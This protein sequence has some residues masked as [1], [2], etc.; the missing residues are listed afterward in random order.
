[1][2]NYKKLKE[3]KGIYKHL[4][5]G[6]FMA[7]KKVKGRDCQE[8]FCT[9]FEAK[10]WLK[11]QAP[12]KL[13]PL[14]VFSTL[15]EVWGAM[16]R[17]HFPN[18]A[19]ST[20]EMWIRRYE[21]WKTIE[22]L[23]M[24]AITPSKISSWIN[25][26]TQCYK[27]DFYAS[28]GRGKAGRCNLNNE[29]NLFVT[30]FNW[31]KESEEFEAEAIKL[32]CPIKKKH[33]KEG[34]I[35]P[36]PQKLKQISFEEAQR[37]WERLKPLYRNLAELQFYTASRIGEVA[38]LQWKNIDLANR[39]LLIKETSYWDNRKKVFV[40]LNPFPKTKEIRVCFITDE[41]M[42]ILLK[43]KALQIPGN[44]FV[45]H[46]EGKPLNYCSIQSNYRGGQRKSGVPYSGS[47]IMR[48]GMAYLARKVGG[49]EAVMAMTG[50][51]DIKLANHYSKGNEHDQ[52]ETSLKIMEYLRNS[53]KAE[54]VAQQPMD[55]VVSIL[56]KSTVN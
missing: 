33:R 8:T 31:Y 20:Q 43:Q 16:L 3:A 48:H 35:K 37:F 50:H 38:G 41:I 22:H 56:Q 12:E 45:F 53:A 1:M 13:K 27:S 30:I 19:P 44:D 32:T 18:L 25:T 17:I 55:N 42:E 4:S 54:Q 2:K 24:N 23:P 34:F 11:D 39:R 6:R 9:L 21:P 10:K 51:K 28:S 15:S 29:L 49:L 36:T 46:I 14:E 52:K 26:L 40:A 5:S 7:R 47:H